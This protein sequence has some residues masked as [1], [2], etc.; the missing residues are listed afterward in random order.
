MAVVTAETSVEFGIRF[1]VENA[2]NKVLFFAPP[3]RDALTT[4]GHLREEG[5]FPRSRTVIIARLFTFECGSAESPAD[6]AS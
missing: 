3:G 6:R 1:R 5:N 2:L 4:Q